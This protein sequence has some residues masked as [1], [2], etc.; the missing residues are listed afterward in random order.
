MQPCVAWLAQDC[1]PHCAGSLLAYCCCCRTSTHDKLAHLQLQSRDCLCSPCRCYHWCRPAGPES[2]HCAHARW[3]SCC[4]LGR[5]LCL[6]HK[7]SGCRHLSKHS[8][9]SGCLTRHRS[10]AFGMFRS[11]LSACSEGVHACME[12][13]H[14]P[15]TEARSAV[16]E[17]KLTRWFSRQLRL[18]VDAF[19]LAARGRSS[20]VT[21][22][23]E[24]N[25]GRGSCCHCSTAHLQWHP[26]LDCLDPGCHWQCLSLCRCLGQC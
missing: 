4:A 23:A 25:P 10:H 17:A 19:V 13:Q 2:V 18:L 8:S 21:A 16:D 24:S 5:F 11:T 12:R 20:K 7:C 6:P 14:L 22:A 3:S 9:S 26:A 1:A 15:T